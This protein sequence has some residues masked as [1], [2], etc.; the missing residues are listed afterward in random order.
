MDTAY[1]CTC[2]PHLFQINN[3]T[4]KKP[5]KYHGFGITDK[6]FAVGHYF[7]V[8]F[9][10]GDKCQSPYFPTSALEFDIQRTVNCDIFL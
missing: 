7:V 1:S 5:G 4:Q 3:I 2:L 10:G 6:A 9:C 8:Y